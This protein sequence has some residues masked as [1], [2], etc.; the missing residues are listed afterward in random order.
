MPAKVLAFR[1]APFLLWPRVQRGEGLAMRTLLAVRLSRC[2]SRVQQLAIVAACCA[3]LAAYGATISPSKLAYNPG[4]SVTLSWSGTTTN[5]YDIV[6]I[7][8]AGAAGT[9]YAPWYYASYAY[10]YQ[11]ANNTYTF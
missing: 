3:P 8:P 1:A 2:V 11:T 6:M 9:A 7:S 4:E 10:R 5:T